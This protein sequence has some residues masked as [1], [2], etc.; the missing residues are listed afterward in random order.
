MKRFDKFKN[1]LFKKDE[2]GTTNHE[3]VAAIVTSFGLVIL[4]GSLVTWLS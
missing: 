2:D 4:V 1:W 3:I